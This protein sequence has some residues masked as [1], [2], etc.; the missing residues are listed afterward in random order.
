MLSSF[1][2]GFFSSSTEYLRALTFGNPGFLSHQDDLSKHGHIPLP[3]APPVEVSVLSREY[4][5]IFS[6][7]C[8]VLDSKLCPCQDRV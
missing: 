7:L 5:N 2:G 4:V 3:K 1:R 6:F 8:T